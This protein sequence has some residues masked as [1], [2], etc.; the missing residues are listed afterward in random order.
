M[1][2][3]LMS[4]L[5]PKLPIL[6]LKTETNKQRRSVFFFNITSQHHPGKGKS[7]AVPTFVADPLHFQ[8]LTEHVNRYIIV[9]N[10]FRFPIPKKRL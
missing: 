7:C 5:S 2:S 6:L 9:F 4:R 3:C 10:S 8:N 1:G